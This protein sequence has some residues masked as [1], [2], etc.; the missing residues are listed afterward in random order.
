MKQML[1]LLFLLLS[2]SFIAKAQEEPQGRLG[3]NPPSVKWY[4][5]ATPT[6]RMIFP[7]GFD[8]VALR[9]GAIM[10]YERVHDQSISGNG[11]T[12]KVTAILQPLSTLPGGFSTPAP[13]RNEYYLTPPQNFFLGPIPWVDGLTIHEYRH[14]E[15]FSKANEGLTLPYQILMGQTGWLLNTLFT[16]PLWFREG[17]AVVN[18]TI[19]TKGGRGRLPSFNMEYR[20]LL[21]SGKQ[22]GYEKAAWNSYKDFIPNPYRLGYYM[23]AKARRDFGEQIWLKVL[24]DVYQKKGFFYPFG[25]S[26]KQFMGFTPVQF[27]GATVKELDSLFLVTDRSLQLTASNEVIPVTTNVYTSYRFGHY[28]PDGAAVVLKNAF[29]ETNTYYLVTADGS[30]QKLFSPGIY[31]E[32]HQTTT[33]AGHMMAWAESAFDTRW[34]NKDYS[35][36]KTYDF[37]TRERKQLTAH[38]RYFSP[39]PSNNGKWIAAVQ[40]ASDGKFNVVVLDAQTGSVSKTFLNPENINFSQPRWTDD[41]S[42]LVLLTLTD[43]GNGISLLHVNTGALT[44]VI[45]ATDV[46]LS[47]PFAKGNYIYYTG[48]YTGIDNIYSIHTETKEIYKVTSVRF[49]A[50]YPAVSADGKKLLFSEYTADGYRLKEMELDPQSWQPL[51]TAPSTDLKFHVPLLKASGRDLSSLKSDTIYPIKKYHAI[52]EGLFNLYGWFPIPNVPEYGA[53]FYTQNIMST[54]RG[55]VGFLYNTNENNFHTYLRFTYAALY[56]VLDAQY[57]YGLMRKGKVY[58]EANSLTKEIT[59]TEN[60]LSGGITLPFRLTQG[61]HRTQLDFSGWYHYYDVNALD[62]TGTG[63]VESHDFFHAI[64]PVMTF[65]RLRVQSRQEVKP[66]WGQTLAVSYEKAM[67]EEPERLTAV[68]RLFFP[69]FYKTHSFNLGLSYKQEKVINTYRFA[70][71]FIMPRGY[72]PAPFETLYGIAVN[73]E[74]PLWYPDI[75][76]SSVALIQRLRL[77][78]YFDYSIGDVLTD[79][80]ILAS[81]G[82]ELLVDLRLFRLFVVSTGIRYSYAFNKDSERTAPVQ[83]LV[84]RFELAN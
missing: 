51:K 34:F 43:E 70:D 50:Y 9:A 60:V 1:L 4:Q 10:N 83:F 82:A 27:Y 58:D 76:L 44:S 20:A 22:Y 78:P 5:M 41:D 19:F 52:T 80:S 77:N 72:K 35:V 71:N 84:T 45:G 75:A 49:G 73:Y 21:L 17:D 54:L 68:G 18:E 55:T 64:E 56:P 11:L 25:R 79:Q 81:A 74:L 3:I 33:V 36:I 57:E 8:S 14:T 39:A 24:D 38:S 29:N 6:G 66:R 31:T 15:Q 47:R 16:Q 40:I 30:E 53:E 59:W 26:M 65:S 42:S 32:D 67:N 23:T 63:E 69:G 2:L 62:T 48:G 13:W 46:P 37:E 61:T 28:L 12:K 7:E